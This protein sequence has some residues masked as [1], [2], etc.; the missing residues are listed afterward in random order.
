M[1]QERLGIRKLTIEEFTNTTKKHIKNVT[2]QITHGNLCYDFY[3]FCALVFHGTISDGL[4]PIE[5]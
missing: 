1:Y 2:A 3:I 4:S 5:H